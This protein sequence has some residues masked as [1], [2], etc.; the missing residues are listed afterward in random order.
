M[1]DLFRSYWWLLFPLSWFII[2]G[3]N[4]WLNYRRSRDA[5]DLMRQY[6]AQGKEP[7]PD[8]MRTL[9]Y[10]VDD[11]GWGR[12][13]YRHYGYRRSW[14]ARVAMFSIL[15]VGFYWAASENLYGAE[16]AFKIVTFVMGA[17]A[18]ATLVGGLVARLGGRDLDRELD[19]DRRDP[20]SP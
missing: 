9:S 12:R 15:A 18:V 14:P 11:D 10:P 4:S 7:P 17:I 16:D 5:M 6:A 3:W 8:L 1:E 20:P 13:R 19:R 2:G